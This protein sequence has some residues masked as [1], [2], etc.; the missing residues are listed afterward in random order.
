MDLFQFVPG[1]SPLLVS[2]PHVGTYIPPDIAARLTP[3]ALT[4]PDT[5]W[6]LP[7]LYDFLDGFR[8]ARL[9][10][11]HS[12]YVVDLN[13]PPNDENLYPGR[14]TTALVPIDTSERLPIYAGPV[15]TAAEIAERRAT[16]WEPYH[17][18]L[19]AAL[20][21][22]RDEHGYALLWDAHSI[23]SVL[24]RFFAGKLWDLNLGTA[25]GRSCGPG[26]GPALLETAQGDTQFSSVL[27]G[28]YKGGW[29]TRSHGRPAERIH[30]FQ[31]ELS[32]ATYM[33]ETPPYA[34]RED[35]ARNVRPVIRRMM[36]R[37]I[38]WGR[39]T[40]RRPA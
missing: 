39:T 15:P 17:A 19:R 3:H 16:Y 40:R 26:L 2:M 12:R 22:I 14:D 34:F 6:H 10:A 20:E 36:E 13:R 28:R 29:I 21:A 8:A 9:I 4:T 32:W 35:L 25:D 1:D 33:D 5:D 11:T 7:Q 30:A 24:P 27:D 18:K 23:K 31:L 38:E 37:M